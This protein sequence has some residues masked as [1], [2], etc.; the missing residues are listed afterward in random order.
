MRYF[1]AV[2]PQPGAAR[3][4][5]YALREAYRRLV[6]FERRN[7]LELIEGR[8]PAHLDG[9]DLILCRNVLIYFDDVSRRCAADHLYGALEPGGF[10][11]LGHTES[12][13]RISPLFHV[14]R[15]ADAIVYR[16]P[17]EDAHG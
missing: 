10:L 13:S 11:C 9:F 6:R 15:Y 2:P 1:R 3:E 12:M 4:G 16:R 7:L 8:A 17:Q 14:C 5:G